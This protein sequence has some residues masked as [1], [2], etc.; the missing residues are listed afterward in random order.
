[1]KYFYENIYKLNELNTLD[2]S[3]LCKFSVWKLVIIGK[4]DIKIQN[5]FYFLNES[6][7]DPVKNVVL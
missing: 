3:K 2:Q 6:L 7:D 5:E 1:M 4:I